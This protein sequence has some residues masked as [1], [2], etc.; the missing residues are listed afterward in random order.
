MVDIIDISAKITK[1]ILSGKLSKEE[2][3]FIALMINKTGDLSSAVSE[4]IKYISNTDDDYQAILDEYSLHDHFKIS[5]SIYLKT[6]EIR[7]TEDDI[8]KMIK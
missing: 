2:S 1:A 8:S 6:K 4:I 7:F 5:A 3:G